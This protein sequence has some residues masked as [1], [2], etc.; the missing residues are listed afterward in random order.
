[1]NYTKSCNSYRSATGLDSVR[2]Q[3]QVFSQ[4][5]VVGN[6]SDPIFVQQQLLS[7]NVSKLAIDTYKAVLLKNVLNSTNIKLEAIKDIEASYGIALAGEA[8]RVKQCVSRYARENSQEILL[9]ISKNAFTFKVSRQ[10]HL[11]KNICSDLV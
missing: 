8:K 6:T 4:S 10:S 7:G 1:M 2:S 3:L 11:K 9:K 5:F